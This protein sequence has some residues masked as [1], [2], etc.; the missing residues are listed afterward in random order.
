MNA[1]VTMG[2]TAVGERAYS[3]ERRRDLDALDMGSSG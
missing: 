3:S 2:E 1:T